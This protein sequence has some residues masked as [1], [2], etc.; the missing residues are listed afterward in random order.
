MVAAVLLTTASVGVSVS[1]TMS[2]A[3][4]ITGTSGVASKCVFAINERDGTALTTSDYE[5]EYQDIDNNGTKDA[6]LKN[7][8]DAYCGSAGCVFE[9]CLVEGNEVVLL[10]FSYA[11]EKL[12][13]KNTYTNNMRDIDLVGKSRIKLVWDYTR[14]IHAR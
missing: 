8:Q 6:V 7:T 4:V 13:I 1:D 12:S 9:I 10:P 5:T 3:S 11:A 2:L 14:Y